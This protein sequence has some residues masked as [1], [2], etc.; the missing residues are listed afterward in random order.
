MQLKPIVEKIRAYFFESEKIAL[1]LIFFACHGLTLIN[2]GLFH[3]DWVEQFLPPL[4]IFNSFLPVGMPFK[5]F[6]HMIIPHPIVHQFVKYLSFLFCGFV[7]LDILKSFN[8][9]TLQRF[10]VAVFFIS[11][12]INSAK[13]SL[14]YTPHL[15]CLLFLFIGSLILI[16]GYQKKSW[17]IRVG[18]WILFF[19]SFQLE[20][21]LVLY[22]LPITGLFLLQCKGGLKEGLRKFV[23]QYVDFLLLPFLYWW[24][25]KNTFFTPF[26]ESVNY[27]WIKVEL[28]EL[29]S[30]SPI[31]ALNLFLKYLNVPIELMGQMSLLAFYGLFILALLLIK[32]VSMKNSTVMVGIF[33]AFTLATFGLYSFFLGVF[34]Y[35]AGGKGHVI[36]IEWT[37]R[38]E[39]LMPIGFGFFF[40]GVLG[41]VH[42]LVR[43]DQFVRM[44]LSLFLVVFV[45]KN[46]E[47]GLGFQ[48]D[49]FRQLALAE[50]FKKEPAFKN[51]KFFIFID[52]ARSLS[53][54]Q[55]YYRQ[56]EYT[57]LFR[58][59]FGDEVRFGVV[60]EMLAA[61]RKTLRQHVES[62]V[63]CMQDFKGKEPTHEVIIR[64]GSYKIDLFSWRMA[65]LMVGR[66]A[67][68]GEFN[69]IIIDMIELKI[70]TI[71]PSIVQQNS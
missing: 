33:Q 34:P 50:H 48:K 15:L 54:Y 11:Y 40:A 68:R 28:K 19:V 53:V 62:P 52:E 65:K 69:K 46:I 45:V 26:G 57:C 18:T 12:P 29:I 61:V 14:T 64:P 24:L 10:T 58:K 31:E 13:V 16:R 63:S 55:R 30:T 25:I 47:I 39:I 22:A 70:K 5:G 60:P 38:Y 9:T 35:I 21:L 2:D 71:S 36:G 41:L 1:A 27:N 7:L 32:R 42:A 23:P 49:W 56:Y 59:T 4:Q 51:G 37:S 66:W 44:T 8:L 20:S 43:S 6:V 17:K 3:D 67:Y